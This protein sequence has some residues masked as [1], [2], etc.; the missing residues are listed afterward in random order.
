MD[1]SEWGKP[2]LPQTLYFQL[3]VFFSKV[4]SYPTYVQRFCGR[5]QKRILEKHSF[6][7]MVWP[8]TQSGHD[9]IMTFQVRWL[10]SGMALIY[11]K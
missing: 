10:G 1:M 3:H 4:H 7:F 11:I 2:C 6:L 5:S 9:G 8:F